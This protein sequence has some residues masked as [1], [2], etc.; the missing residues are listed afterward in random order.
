MGTLDKAFS[1]GCAGRKDMTSFSELLLKLMIY[2]GF[3]SAISRLLI[4]PAHNLN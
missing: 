3:Q 1:A 2:R 4:S